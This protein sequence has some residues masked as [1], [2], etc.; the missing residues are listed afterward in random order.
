MSYD[1]TFLPPQDRI[2]LNIYFS[3]MR[4]TIFITVFYALIYKIYK[5]RLECVI[6]LFIFSSEFH[7]LFLFT[8][9]GINIYMM[10]TLA[11]LRFLAWGTFIT[12]ARANLMGEKIIILNKVLNKIKLIARSK[13]EEMER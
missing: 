2:S 9:W 12:M 4:I 8:R 5:L 6:Y 11:Q 3:T 10:Q 1:V 7:I 13:S